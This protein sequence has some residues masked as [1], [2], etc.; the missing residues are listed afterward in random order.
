[1]NMDYP[2]HFQLIHQIV[3]DYILIDLIQMENIFHKNHNFLCD[4]IK[5]NLLELYEKF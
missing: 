5:L 4:L 2:N 1:M 3:L